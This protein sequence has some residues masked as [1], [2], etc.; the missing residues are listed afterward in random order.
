MVEYFK[1]GEKKFYNRLEK[2]KNDWRTKNYLKCQYYNYLLS[3]FVS[4]S[5]YSRKLEYSQR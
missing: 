2:E 1:D 4:R 5:R 3:I